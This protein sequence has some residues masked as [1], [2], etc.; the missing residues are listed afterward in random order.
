MVIGIIFAFA[1]GIAIVLSRTLNAKL[2]SYSNLRYSTLF[3]YIIGI[4]G[5]ILIVVLTKTKLPETLPTFKLREGGIY[6]GG[7]I[8]VVMVIANSY[9]TRKLPAIIFTLLLFCSQ[10]FTGIAIDYFMS[11]NYSNGKVI[12][13]FII[14]VGLWISNKKEP[15]NIKLDKT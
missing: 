5:S 8:G 12:G 2:T 6:L 14:L 7:A 1:S 15:S 10:L 9:L 13:G 3:N 11:G 4:I